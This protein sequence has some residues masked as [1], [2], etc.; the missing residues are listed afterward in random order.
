[1]IILGDIIAIGSITFASL[2]R[3][4][5]TLD[6]AKE[7]RDE[8]YLLKLG[9]RILW[10]GLARF[11]DWKRFFEIKAVLKERYVGRFVS[12]VATGAAQT[13]LLGDDLRAPD[14]DPA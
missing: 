4:L 7:G 11:E 1:L 12:L 3:L 14:L 9:E 13:I 2:R 6:L 5:F 8:V 10:R